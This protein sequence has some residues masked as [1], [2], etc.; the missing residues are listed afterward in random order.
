MKRTIKKLAY[1][2]VYSKD[3][4]ETA[5]FFKDMFDWVITEGAEGQLYVSM[6]KYHHRISIYQREEPGLKA[7]GWQALNSRDFLETAKIL[8]TAGVP[9]VMGSEAECEERKVR[10]FLSFTDPSGNTVEICY[11]PYVVRPDITSI[12]QIDILDLLH[13]TLSVTEE[14]FANNLKFYEGVLGFNVSDFA[15][16][17]NAF[18]RCSENHHN[19]AMVT[20]HEPGRKL[21]HFMF[22]VANLD[23][24]M[25]TY[26]RAKE[27][28]I[29]IK[30]PTKHGNCKT[31]HVY[32][33]IPGMGLA[34]VE[35]GWGHKKIMD[36]DQWEV[37]CYDFKDERLKEFIDIWSSFKQKN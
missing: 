4:L 16:R 30:G 31:V 26:Y 36:E 32:M 19:F 6:D 37:V 12:G 23:D 17:H 21:R 9:Y 8:E 13:V 1:L 28:N 24:V 5:Q 7:I 2:H 34:E 14:Q 20:S 22:E 3:P 10:A 35:L 29:P 33:Q 11:S 18:I 15:G 27:R 25:K